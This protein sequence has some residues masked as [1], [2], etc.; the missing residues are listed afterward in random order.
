M[1]PIASDGMMIS[2]TVVEYVQ[3]AILRGD[4]L[5]DHGLRR[6]RGMP[7]DA[8][9]ELYGGGTLIFDVRGNLKYHIRIHINDPRRQ[10]EIIE[11]LVERGEYMTSLTSF[12]SL[13]QRRTIKSATSKARGETWP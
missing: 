7:H 8:L 5:N 12:A 13:H 6:P 9:I 1:I 2:E 10:N 4:E 3:S 11:H